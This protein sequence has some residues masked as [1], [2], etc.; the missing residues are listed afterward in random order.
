MSIPQVLENPITDP[1]LFPHSTRHPFDDV[2]E[3]AL[4]AFSSDISYAVSIVRQATA[5]NLKRESWRLRME[6][7][8]GEKQAQLLCSQAAKF[9]C[10]S[11]SPCG[12]G[13]CRFASAELVD[14]ECPSIPTSRPRPAGG[15]AFSVEAALPALRKMREDS[16]SNPTA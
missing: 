9:H 4:E 8:G 16:N 5:L 2:L 12:V 11:V 7:R 15:Y 6:L 3:L 1:T 13:S 14:L 10:E